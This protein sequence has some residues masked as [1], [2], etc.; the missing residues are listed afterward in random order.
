MGA[1]RIF[2]AGADISEFGKPAL[3]LHLPDVVATIEAC[4]KPVITAINGT[5]LGGGLEIALGCHYRLAHPTAKLGLP[6]VTLGIRDETLAR[7]IACDDFASLA[8]CDLI[9][10]AAFESPDVKRDIFVVLGRICKADAVL[11]TNTSY[12]DVDVIAAASGRPVAV[13]GMHYFSPAHVMK[14]LEIVRPK[15]ADSHALATTLRVAKRTDKQVVFAGVCKAS[16]AIGC[17][18]PLRARLAFC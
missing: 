16:S 18:S 9:V 13:V 5:A 10:E 15:N 2:V 8:D 3:A 1:G 12:L 17:S 14:L 6:E 7:L 11:A 4:S